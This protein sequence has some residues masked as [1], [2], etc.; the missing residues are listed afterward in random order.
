MVPNYGKV[1]A[2]YPGLEISLSRETNNRD[3]DEFSFTLIFN[4]S[5]D[6]VMTIKIQ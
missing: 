4:C 1:A 6:T 3:G 2:P 5:N